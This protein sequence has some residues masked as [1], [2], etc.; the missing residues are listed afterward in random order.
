[1]SHS[2]NDFMAD[3]HY[4]LLKPDFFLKFQNLPCMWWH[5]YHM[6]NYLDRMSNATYFG[7]QLNVDAGL[8]FFFFI[9]VSILYFLIMKFL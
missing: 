1:M 5:N 2:W 9:L 8:V 7:S 3:L 4:C 6:R